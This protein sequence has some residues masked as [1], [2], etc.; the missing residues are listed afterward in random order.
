MD[1]RKPESKIRLGISQNAKKRN[2]EK[3]IGKL[4]LNEK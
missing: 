4:K 3:K 2:K 1:Q